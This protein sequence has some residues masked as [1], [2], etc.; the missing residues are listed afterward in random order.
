MAEW[1]TIASLSTAAG[2]LVLAVA[3]FSSVRASQRSA[4]IAEQALLIG[5]RPVLAPSREDDP[6][7]TVTFADRHIVTVPGGGASVELE[8]D[9]FC[10]VMPLRNVGAGIAVLHSWR[11]QPR[12]GI[13]DEPEIEALRRQTRDLF[14]PAGE[15]GFWQAAMREHDD[16]MR[17]GLDQI[18]EE[19]APFTIDLLYS[20]HEGGQRAVSRFTMWPTDAGRWLPALSRHFRLDGVNPR[21]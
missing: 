5:R 20:D 2:T 4:R 15:I 1:S 17:A 9:R 7:Q 8:D 3:T 18:Y 19:R 10:F 14:I 13:Q 21:A 6:Q 12:I 16:E 11:I